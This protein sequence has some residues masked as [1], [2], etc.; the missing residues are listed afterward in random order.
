MGPSGSETKDDCAGEDQQQ[1]TYQSL[2]DDMHF[3]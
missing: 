1:V 2:E 3:F